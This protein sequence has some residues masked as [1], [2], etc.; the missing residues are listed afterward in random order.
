MDKKRLGLI[1]GFFCVCVLLGFALYWV[2]FRDPQVAVVPPGTETP[3]TQE[4]SSLPEPGE[5][6]PGTVT[7]GDTTLP[8]SDTRDDVGT[9]DDDRR[10]RVERVVETGITSPGVASNGAMQFY[11]RQ[12]GRFYKINANGEMELLSDEVF[13]NVQN[14]TWS[15]KDSKSIIEYPDGSNIYYDFSTKKQV[16]LPKHWEEFSF[17]ASGSGIAAKS[18]GLSEENR[19]LITANPEGNNIRLVEPMGANAN[20]VQV[21]WS[22]NRQ[23]VAT[24]RTGQ[25]L[26][27]DREEVLFVGLNDENFRAMVVE[28][29]GFKGSW[30]PDGAKMLYSVYSPRS[31]FRPELWIVNA[32][33]DSIGEERTLLNVN[34]WPEKCSFSGDRFIYCG[35]P[36]TLQSGAGI[37]PAIADGTPDK[38]YR[39]D[40]QTG[41][42]T[43]LPLQ[44]EGHVVEKMFLSDDGQTLFFTDK[45]QPGLFKLPI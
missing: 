37:A 16:T 22:P 4:P 1:I 40:T 44:S 36:E 25:A 27:A 23:I 17:D 8:T 28:G 30:S 33:P 14:V 29:R 35:V 19:W 42:K 34:T 3:G 18:V 32:T 10:L 31:D 41:A 15:P 12:D 26:G 2:F 9:E 38:I 13:F 11:N 45:Q 21:N 39:I 6:E 5:R 7:P 24:S 43:E 20:K